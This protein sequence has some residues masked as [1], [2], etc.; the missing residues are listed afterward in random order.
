MDLVPT[1]KKAEPLH[2][3]WS[4][5]ETLGDFLEQK[6]VPLEEFAG[7][8]DGKRISAK[9]AKLVAKVIADNAAWYDMQ[10]GGVING[11]CLTCM[12]KDS[13]KTGLAMRHSKAWAESGGF[14]KC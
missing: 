8:N 11:V 14:K 3:N 13:P 6:G 10:F 9:T 7:A 12:R 5:W 4:G 2:Y 1:N